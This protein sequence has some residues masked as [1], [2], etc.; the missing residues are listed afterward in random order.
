MRGLILGCACSSVCV[1]KY[2]QL[3]RAVLLHFFKN[4]KTRVCAH[5]QTSGAL[6]RT[7]QCTYG[8]LDARAILL[9]FSIISGLECVCG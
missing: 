1:F 7:M 3:G 4:K 2:F 5:V 9:A 8:F 6:E